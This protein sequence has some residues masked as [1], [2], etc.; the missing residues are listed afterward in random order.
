MNKEQ[1][2]NQIKLKKSFLCI[3]LDS[4]SSKIPS[5][6]QYADD[7]VFEFNKQIIEAT[8]HL[9]VAYKPN[10]AFYEANGIKG[11]NSLE[12][13]A[14]FI[15]SNYPELF[16][17]ADAKRGDIGNTSDMYARA[18][19]QNMHFDAVTLSPYMGFDTVQ[20]FLQHKDKWAIVLALT[21][22]SSAVDF[23][24]NCKNQSND[25]LW[26]Q[27]LY[28]SKDWASTDQL[29]YVVGATK[30]EWLRKVR[31]I[32]PEHFLLVPGIGAQ[33][34]SLKEVAL[35]GMNKQCGLLVNSSRGIIFASNGLNF[36]SKARE[37]ALLVQ[38]EMAGYLKDFGLLTN[39]T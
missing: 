24:T 18:F 4:D 6:L 35:N 21:S 30:A 10:L 2:F 22:N 33:G 19:F 7:P 5:H 36:A 16:L 34:G 9:A 23:Q 25:M 8:H 11:W 13:T 14:Q 32:V 26:Q 12:R 31:E 29:M 38:T 3:G 1:L 39:P 20:P 17:I 15:K 28:T 27:V 37:E